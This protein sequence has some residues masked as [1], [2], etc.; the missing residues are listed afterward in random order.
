M[1]IFQQ[2][3]IKII[4]EQ[5]LIIGPLAWHEAQKVSGIKIIN[6]VKGEID[7]VGNNPSQVLD[8]LVNQYERIFGKT[9]REV[10]K[11]AAASLIADLSPNEVPLSLQ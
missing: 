8:S 11:E 10:C 4:K 5:E 9:S 2:I 1:S 7:F 6:Q 3:A